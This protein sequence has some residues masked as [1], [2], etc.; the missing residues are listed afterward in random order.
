[1]LSKIEPKNFTEASEDMHWIDAME[2]ELNKI[3]KNETWELVPRPTDKNVIGTKWGFR[4][5]LDEY[6]KVIR[7]KAILVCEGYAQVKDIDLEETFVHVAKLE[8]IRMF[9]AFACFKNFQI[10]SNGCQFFLSQWKFRGTSIHLTTIR[11]LIIR[12]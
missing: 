11:I 10:L 9:L 5:K 1:L 7:N 8:A 2:E 4:N 3:E 12:K 6:G